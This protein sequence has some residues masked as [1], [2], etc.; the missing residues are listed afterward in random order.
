MP[1]ASGHTRAILSS[2]VHGTS[3]YSNTGDKLGDL[4][5]VVLDKLS[6]NIMFA[7]LYSGGLMGMGEKYF[8]IPW[9]VL[10]YDEDKNGYV[11]PFDKERLK[12]APVYDKDEL[13]QNDGAV[14]EKAFDYFEAEPYWV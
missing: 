5:D 13:I 14:R 3:I 8:A 10:D 7:I 12:A 1:T 6:D 2:K 9:S 4:E 11:V